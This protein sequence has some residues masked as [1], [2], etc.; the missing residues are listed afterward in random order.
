MN[1]RLVL[2]HGWGATAEDLEPLGRSLAASMNHEMEVM[3]LEAPHLHP[4]PP[5]RQWYALFPADWD[6]VPAAIEALQQR[7]ASITSQGAPMKRTV[8]LGFSQGGAMA[9]HSGCSLPLAGV[10]SCSGYPHPDWQ[11]GEQHPPV[12]AMHG[13]QDTIVPLTA[14]NAIAERL[15]SDRYQTISFD[16]GHTIPEEMM[17]P[18]LAFLKRTL[19]QS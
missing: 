2:L 19:E 3:A 11:A 15:Q 6:A 4:Q 12:L 5:G 18:M 17:Q 1:S 9:L 8:L 7:L 13:Q 16:N 10:I 14:L